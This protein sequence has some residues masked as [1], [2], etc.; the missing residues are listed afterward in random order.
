MFE[1][2]YFLCCTFLF[3]CLCI[4]RY[5]SWCTYNFVF[6]LC[7]INCRVVYLISFSII[8]HSHRTGHL[9]ACQWSLCDK[10]FLSVKLFPWM[11]LFFFFFFFLMLLFVYLTAM[12]SSCGMWDLVPWPGIEPRPPALGVWCLTTGPS[13]R[14]LDLFLIKDLFRSEISHLKNIIPVGLAWWSGG[15]DSTLPV[16]EA[17]VCCLVREL[18]PTWC[19]Q[20]LE[21]LSKEIK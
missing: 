20:D 10:T 16:Q 3:L 18:D 2:F 14:S 11:D 15:W 19:N 17:R 12:G 21:L 6:Y 5:F 8:S 4:L 1:H 13:G 9:V 7:I